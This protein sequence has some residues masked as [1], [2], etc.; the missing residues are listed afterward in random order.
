M[1]RRTTRNLAK[2]IRDLR[3]LLKTHEFTVQWLSESPVDGTLDPTTTHYGAMY[4]D[5]DKEHFFPSH[6]TPI[7]GGG[8]GGSYTPT[9][10]VIADILYKLS[11][12]HSITIQYLMSIDTNKQIGIIWNDKDFPFDE[13][14]GMGTIFV[15]GVSSDE[16]EE[17]NTRMSQRISD[18]KKRNAES[19]EHLVE[20]LDLWQAGN[21][22]DHFYYTQKQLEEALGVTISRSTLYL[23]S[24]HRQNGASP[25]P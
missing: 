12:N 9:D 8:H 10:E 11:N 17:M 20:Y 2:D 14:T 1:E 15:E 4:I 3:K 21:V 7:S 24:E 13:I 5:G 22:E 23:P 16:M 18:A 25:D 19:L 6:S